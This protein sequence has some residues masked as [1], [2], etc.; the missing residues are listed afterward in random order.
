M[1]QWIVLDDV[2]DNESEDGIDVPND[3]GRVVALSTVIGARSIT[4]PFALRSSW[5]SVK[6]S[7]CGSDYATKTMGTLGF[8]TSARLAD[9]QTK[10]SRSTWTTTRTDFNAQGAPQEQTPTASKACMPVRS[11]EERWKASE[12][13]C[14]HLSGM[15]C[16]GHRPC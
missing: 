12:S 2:T 13:Y 8:F 1:I 3:D 7:G 6:C 16:F 4:T 9:S 15:F 11:P 14:V 5:C 10:P